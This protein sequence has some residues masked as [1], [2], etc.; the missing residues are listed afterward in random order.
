[1]TY[2]VS[3]WWQQKNAQESVEVSLGQPEKKPIYVVSTDPK[4]TDGGWASVKLEIIHLRH[5]YSL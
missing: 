3:R 1:M 5:K 4:H 2:P